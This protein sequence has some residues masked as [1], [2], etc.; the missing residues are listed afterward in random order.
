MLDFLASEGPDDAFVSG[1]SAS[2]SCRLALRKASI[3]L[4]DLRGS[5]FGTSGFGSVF[6]VE[7]TPALTNAGAP[8]LDFFLATLSSSA[9]SDLRLTLPEEMRRLRLGFLMSIRVYFMSQFAK[10]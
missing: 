9:T 4:S 7:A 1:D 6:S 5:V 2:T 10:K 3:S 8:Y